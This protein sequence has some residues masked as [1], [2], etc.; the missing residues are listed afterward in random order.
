[1]QQNRVADR[2]VRAVVV[3]S[4]DGEAAGTVPVRGGEGEQFRSDRALGGIVALGQQHHVSGGLAVEPHREAARAAALAGLV[5]AHADEESGAV[6]VGVVQGHIRRIK[7]AVLEVRR[8]GV[9]INENDIT[10]GAVRLV[11]ILPRDRDGLHGGPRG[12]VEREQLA[13]R[14]GDGALVGEVVDELELHGRGRSAIQPNRERARAACFGSG[15]IC[16]GDGEPGSLVIHIAQ[17]DI[18]RVNAVVAWIAGGGCTKQHRIGLIPVRGVVVHAAHGHSVVGLPVADREGHS[19]GRAK[20]GTVV[21]HQTL[22]GDTGTDGQ[23]DGSRGRISELDREGRGAVVLMRRAADRADQNSARRITFVVLVDAGNVLRVESVVAQIRTRRTRQRH[24]EGHRVIQQGVI[25]PQDGHGLR[26]RVVS[27]TEVQ[28]HRTCRRTASDREQRFRGIADGQRDCDVRGGRNHEAD[29]EGRIVST[30]GR[31]TTESADE[32]ARNPRFVV[33]VTQHHILRVQ[34]LIVCIRAGG[35]RQHDGEGLLAVADIVILCD[36]RDRLRPGASR[37]KGQVVGNHRAA[38]DDQLRLGGIAGVHR[39][40]HRGR[41]RGVQ[42][43]RE[44]CVSAGLSQRGHA[45][46]ADADARAV[47]IHVEQLHIRRIER[48][49]LGR[50]GRAAVDSQRCK[51]TLIPVR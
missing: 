15:V 39:N 46:S 49:V 26:G 10:L 47:V 5:V 13:R 43:H 19:R 29:R 28:I 14:S 4:S 7:V 21:R 50:R 2:A 45:G 38:V 51:I 33:R 18:R 36:H 16:G 42:C 48:V 24:R 17:R 31:R 44:G 30:F 8:G 11:V 32:E 41:G 3:E 25:L 20:A 40:C 27:G 9:R 35:F 34:A 22:T 1:M 12:A 37:S 23:A 6:V